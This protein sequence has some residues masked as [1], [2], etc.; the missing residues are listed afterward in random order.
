MVPFGDAVIATVDTCLGF[1]ICEELWNPHSTHIGL[2]EDG[3]EIIV[4]GSGSY[5]ELRKSNVIVDLVTSATSKVLILN[6]PF[7]LM[8]GVY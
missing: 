6:D 7:F 1:E 8:S 3:V 5:F 2:A 4:N